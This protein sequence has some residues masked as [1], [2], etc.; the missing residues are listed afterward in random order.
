MVVPPF[1]TPKW[2]FLVGKPMVVGETHHFRKPPTRPLG[3]AFPPQISRYLLLSGDLETPSAAECFHGTSST[4]DVG[5]VVSRHPKKPYWCPCR[6]GFC[7][8]CKGSLCTASVSELWGKMFGVLFI[9][10]IRCSRKDCRIEW[11]FSCTI[12]YSTWF[13]YSWD[14]W[15]QVVTR[16]VGMGHLSLWDFWIDGI[17]IPPENGH[18]NGTSTIWRCISYWTWGCSNV[19]L[20]FRGVQ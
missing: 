16:G 9:R 11:Y 5:R 12:L 18:D 15:H 20:V 6:R 8:R 2:S 10:C 14:W 3:A 19:M 7:L 13:V 4:A 17:N 1:H